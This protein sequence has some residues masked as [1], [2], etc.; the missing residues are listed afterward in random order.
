MVLI[1]CNSS[2]LLPQQCSCL[3]TQGGATDLLNL[4]ISTAQYLGRSEKYVVYASAHGALQVQ[5]LHCSH[6]KLLTSSAVALNQ[7]RSIPFWGLLCN[8]SLCDSALDMAQRLEVQT[9]GSTNDNGHLS[10]VHVYQD[11]HW[12]PI[13]CL[14]HRSL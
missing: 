9:F 12:L 8:V 14:I 13:Y 1:G 5:V 4:R 2:T 6:T 7:S 3:L 11:V 10:V